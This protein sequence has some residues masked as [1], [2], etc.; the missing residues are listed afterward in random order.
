MGIESLLRATFL[1]CAANM[2]GAHDGGTRR[3][4]Q[5]PD[6]TPS[7]QPQPCASEDP[8][9]SRHR[10]PPRSTEPCTSF[11]S[12]DLILCI[13]CIDSKW[14]ISV[15][16]LLLKFSDLY[17]TSVICKN[18][19]SMI[20]VALLVQ[21]LVEEHVSQTL[22]LPSPFADPIFLSNISA[23]EADIQTAKLHF[24]DGRMVCTCCSLDLQ[25]PVQ[26]TWNTC[27]LRRI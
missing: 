1:I 8:G 15:I 23:P 9:D 4:F 24:T 19:F 7:V 25:E 21:S 14:S 27:A 5:G 16:S 26:P 12:L 20:R 17:F 10:V 3:D 2:S 13:Y 11:S 22:A 18:E 6:G